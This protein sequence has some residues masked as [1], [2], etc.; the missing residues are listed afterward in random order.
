MESDG[1]EV[2]PR[3]SA[4]NHKNKTQR[5]QTARTNYELRIRSS[6]EDK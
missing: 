2:T 5:N 3:I 6:I 1:W 4:N